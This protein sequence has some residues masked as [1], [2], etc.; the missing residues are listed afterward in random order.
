MAKLKY[1]ED[2]RRMYMP[3]S[4]GSVSGSPIV[5]GSRVGV[6]LT[7]R[8]AALSASVDFKGVYGLPVTGV[9]AVG[10]P[11][12]YT[13]DA[14]P[15]LRLGVVATGIFAG[16]ALEVN[17]GGSKTTMKVYVSEASGVSTL[18]ANSL[19][20]LVAGNNADDGVIGS[21]PV[22]HR[23]VIAAGAVGAKNITLTYKTRVVQAWVVMTGAGVASCT[24]V[25]GN[26][27][28]AITN[29]MDVSV[30]DTTIV[31][32][33]QINDANH[34]IAGGGSLRI[35]TATGATQPNM[36]VYVLGVRVA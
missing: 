32:A 28:S 29:L 27:A 21:I 16:Y 15:S 3:V 13:E 17:G 11:V 31:R 30:A 7:D 36:I 1:Y 20:G 4:A 25:V 34:E 26:G 35:T 10:T 9:T 14:D 33:T 19:T 6:A 5:V 23:V 2:G 8:D 18:S 24:C 12:Y 22:L